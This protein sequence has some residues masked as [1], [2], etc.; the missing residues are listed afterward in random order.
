MVMMVVIYVNM[1]RRLNFLNRF[2]DYSS[3]VLTFISGLLMLFI[4]QNFHSGVNFQN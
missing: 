2:I 3:H 1:K 4:Y